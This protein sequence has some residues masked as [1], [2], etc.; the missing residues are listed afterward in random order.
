MKNSDHFGEIHMFS[1][2]PLVSTYYYSEASAL[3]DFLSKDA[4]PKKHFFNNLLEKFRQRLGQI[5]LK[6]N[7]SIP[8]ERDPEEIKKAHDKYKKDA[9]DEY[10]LFA[11]NLHRIYNKYTNQNKQDLPFFIS[12]DEQK[13]GAASYVTRVTNYAAEYV[14]SLAPSLTEPSTRTNIEQ[15]RAERITAETKAAKQLKYDIYC[16][17]KKIKNRKS[18][19]NTAIF[20][21]LMFSFILPASLAWFMYGGYQ[22]YKIYK[23]NEKIN[24]IKEQLSLNYTT[25]DDFD[26]TRS[27][28]PLEQN[29][30]ATKHINA[31]LSYTAMGPES[32]LKT[33]NLPDMRENTKDNLA[34][35]KEIVRYQELFKNRNNIIIKGRKAG[36]QQVT[37]HAATPQR[38]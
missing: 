20:L 10:H 4:T 32:I 35:V 23:E 31:L 21:G 19:V 11:T 27:T 26:Y 15:E 5:E 9:N 6:A 1:N 24:K 36:L 17:E 2:Q 12:V 25:N 8:N 28:T 13:P 16:C 18:K 3:T 30:N 37:P 33:C 34:K 38:R 22:Q 7:Q 14:R 29:P